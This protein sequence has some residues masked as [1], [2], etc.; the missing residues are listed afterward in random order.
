LLLEP[1][2]DIYVWRVMQ[3]ATRHIFLVHLKSI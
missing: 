1:V 3:N 2:F